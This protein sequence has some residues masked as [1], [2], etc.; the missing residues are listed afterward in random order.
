MT[1]KGLSLLC[2]GALVHLPGQS[3]RIA[4]LTP[5][6]STARSLENE[7]RRGAIPSL[8]PVWGTRPH[9][10]PRTAAL[11]RDFRFRGSERASRPLRRAICTACP[12]T[13]TRAPER[14][15]VS[16]FPVRP[17]ENKNRR[18]AIPSLVPVRGTRPHLGPRTAALC[19]DFRFRGSE[20]LSRPLRRAIRTACPETCTRAPERVS[21]SPFPVRPLE[22]ENRRGAIPSLVP[23]WGTRPHLGPRTAAL[24]RDFR[25]RGSERL[26]RPLRR[27]VRTACPET[28]TRAPERASVSP[29]PVR[30][31]ENENRRGAIP[32]LVPVRGTRPHLG[33][34]TA[35]LCRDFRFRGSERLSRPLRRAVRTA[36]PETCT[37]APERA[38]VSP[39]PVRP[40]ENENRRGAI[41]SLVPVR[42]T[43]PHLGPRTAALCRD[44]RFRGSEQV[45]RPL[46]RAV[47][48]ACPETCT[49][50]PERVSVSPFPVRPLEN[51]NRRGAI[52]SLV[53]VRRTRPHLGPRTAVL[54]RDFRFRG[55]ER[56][57]R[58]LRRAVRTACPET[59]TRAPERASVSP[60]PVRPL[61]NENRRG[62]IPSLVPVR[63]TRPHLGPRTAALCRDFRCRGSEQV[64]RPL[65]RA[66]HTACPETCTSAPERVS[67]SPFPVRPLENENR[68]GAI[69]S[70]VP[71]W[72]TRPHLGPR[73]AA[74]CRDFRFRGSER[75]SR[76]LRRAV[77][78]ACPETC[79]RVPER[80]SV[81]PFPV[82]PLENE[83][84]RGAIPSLV[85]VRGTRPHLG[86]RTA[87][88]CRDF[89]FRGSERS[90]RPLRRAVCTACPE[91][92]TRAPVRASVSPFPVRTLENEN[93]RGAIPSLVPVRGTRP[94]LGPRTAAL[95]RDF[96]FRGS[97]RLSR[98]LRRAVRTACPETCTR[99]PERASVSPFPVRPLENENRRGAIPSLVPVRGT[100][101]HLGPRTAAL[102]RDFRFRG[103]ERSTRPLRRAVRTACP[104]T[105]TRAPERVSV[106]PFPVRPLE[107]E[108]RRGAIPSLVPVRGTRPHL[109]PRSAA[110]C[111]D[112]RFRGNE[113]VSRPL[114]RAVRTACPETC[115]R[116][117]ERVSVSPFPVRPLE[118]ENRRGAI[119]SLVPVRGTHGRSPCQVWGTLPPTL[120]SD[121]SPLAQSPWDLRG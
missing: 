92:C 32:S 88:L 72:G 109:G 20:R 81:S 79:T 65:R 121:G 22:N 94:H 120:R 31:L 40:L 75:V 7:N 90:T 44:F 110:L 104:E 103:S 11:C 14:A 55:S 68:Q 115:T 17:L 1:E 58:A 34:R 26:S 3:G 93:R 53:P 38:S 23:V 85:P 21:V 27:A 67:V 52:P 95:C 5:L 116:A 86:P 18:G 16:P 77:R 91:T 83:N 62:A 118:N 71:V 60:F 119:P 113:Q 24:C 99:A 51:E 46:R 50:A 78:T 73:T 69:P 49:S 15:S 2:P 39:F 35:A 47:H 80:A 42:G 105:C 97:E 37:R 106:S 4:L 28:C 70:L 64:S 29:F 48:T 6:D 19:R 10:G 84:R 96:R 13:C 117:P 111:R 108:N 98:P 45:S 43:R 25:F 41:P 66:V 102:C 9:L 74:L 30:P 61:E 56:A 107:N 63:G 36:C 8:V 76:P 59:C 89:R 12:E 33:P 87:A 82:R 112:F 114:R 54:C 100:R 57:S 101:P